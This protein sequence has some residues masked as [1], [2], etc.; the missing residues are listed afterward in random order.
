MNKKIVLIILPALLMATAAF[1]DSMTVASDATAQWSS[2]NTTWS[3]AV[4]TWVHPSWP[5][6][7]GATWIWRT[8]ETDA[9]WEYANVPNGG[10]YFQKTF[11]VPECADMSTI[12]G[13]LQVNADNSESSSINSTLLG[14]DGSLNKDGP[15]S[16]E[17]STIESYDIS[18]YLTKGENTLLFR[19]LNY[20][21]Y[22]PYNS[23]PA[24]LVFKADVTYTDTSKIDSDGDGVSD[25]EDKCSGTIADAP[26]MALGTNRWIWNGTNWVT[27]LPAKGKGPPSLFADPTIFDY[28]YGCSCEQILDIIKEKTGSNLEGHYKYGCSRSILEDWRNGKYYLETVTV[29]ANGSPTET[30]SQ[31]AT[32][33]TETYDIKAHGTAWANEYINFDALCSFNNGDSVVSTE[34]TDLVAG[35]EGY[36][37]TLLDLFVNGN[38]LWGSACDASHVYWG[39]IDGDG[40]PLE[41]VVND[42]Y[43][44][45]NFGSLFA[46]IYVRLW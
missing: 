19:A 22:G 8:A 1:A 29:P 11:E 7:S 32:K 20:F 3:P 38:T 37:A 18:G 26:P 31:T 25:C 15:D 14:Q 27:L 44:S 12:T 13:T 39:E 16:Q 23:N 28:T 45:N 33:A 46:D 41:F 5:S 4:A 17:W 24:G 6:I 30:L 36:G 21:N 35:Y 42:F 2:D 43:P 10:W 34:W 40:N 9:P